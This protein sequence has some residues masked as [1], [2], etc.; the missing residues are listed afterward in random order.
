MLGMLDI[1]TRLAGLILIIE[2]KMEVGDYRQIVLSAHVESK[3]GNQITHSYFFSH[4]RV[5]N[6]RGL[7]TTSWSID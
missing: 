1:Y 5:D 4:S 6:R 7:Q 3:L 2:L